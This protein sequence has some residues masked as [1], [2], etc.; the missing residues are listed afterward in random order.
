MGIVGKLWVVFC[1]LFSGEH[2]AVELARMPHSDGWHRKTG[3]VVGRNW[4]G[5]QLFFS[6]SYPETPSTEHRKTGR[7]REKRVQMM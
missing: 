5:A 2:S 3:V 6:T 7:R 1:A 4:C